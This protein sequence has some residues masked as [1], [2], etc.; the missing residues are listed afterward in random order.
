MINNYIALQNLIPEIFLT[1]TILIFILFEID[2]KSRMD[3]NCVFGSASGYSS[4]QNIYFFACFQV[5]LITLILLLSTNCGASFDNSLLIN[6]QSTSLLKEKFIAISLFILVF[7]ADGIKLQKLDAKWFYITFLFAIL[8][9]LLILSVNDF[10]SDRLL[11]QVGLVLNLDIFTIIIKLNN[12]LNTLF[13]FTTVGVFFIIIFIILKAMLLP[14]F[15]KIYTLLPNSGKTICDS[16]FFGFVVFYKNKLHPFIFKLSMGLFFSALQIPV[17]EASS[18]EPG[19]TGLGAPTSPVASPPGTPE[20]ELERWWFPLV[21]Q[22]THTNM[23]AES[24]EDTVTEGDESSGGDPE[25][26]VLMVPDDAVWVGTDVNG[27]PVPPP[28][29][30]DRHSHTSLGLMGHCL[31]VPDVPNVPDVAAVTESSITAQT[32]AEN[33]QA[34][35]SEDE[36]EPPHKIARNK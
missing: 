33:T 35:L 31:R 1:L 3:N 20:P 22:Q 36:E 18:P 8:L 9:F 4:K 26:G 24:F 25:L 11:E 16:I 34:V 28:E 13:L 29:H 30:Y 14:V 12:N 6:T 15:G 17:A 32:T 21:S 7:V 19:M 27:R 23:M 10:I 2:D 5:L